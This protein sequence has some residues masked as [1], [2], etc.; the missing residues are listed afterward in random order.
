MF[1]APRPLHTKEYL[2]KYRVPRPSQRTPE[3]IAMVPWGNLKPESRY[4]RTF[5]LPLRLVI[6]FQTGLELLA[7]Q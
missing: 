4:V 7:S 3:A 2:E 1:R 6:T 5:C